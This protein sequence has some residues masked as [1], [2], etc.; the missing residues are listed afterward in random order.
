[1]YN[2]IRYF[3]H[4]VE[5]NRSSFEALPITIEAYD[6]VIEYLNRLADKNY[7]GRRRYI[8]NLVSYSYKITE[9]NGNTCKL[10]TTIDIKKDLWE[11]RMSTGNRNNI[12][13]PM[14][15]TVRTHLRFLA[16]DIKRM[17]DSYSND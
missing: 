5:L 16:K 10:T 15:L 12:S 2:T 3:E 11:G 9:E 4:T 13:K 14:L 1:M 6:T 8:Q 7:N 17:M